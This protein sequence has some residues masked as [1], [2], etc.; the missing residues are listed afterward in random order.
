MRLAYREVLTLG[1]VGACVGISL[2]FT[3]QFTVFGALG[4]GETMG[5]MRRMGYWG[6]VMA[7]SL[8]ISYGTA[9]LTMYVVREWRQP[10]IVL[11][12]VAAWA[13]MAA[14]C[15]AVTFTSYGV[16]QAVGTPAVA[17]PRVA[18]HCALTV[19]GAVALMY[20]VLCVRV[21][22]RSRASTAGDGVMAKP[23]DAVASRTDAAETPPSEERN[24][25]SST[26]SEEQTTAAAGEHTEA[27]PSSR[28]FDRLPEELGTDI[29]YLAAAAHYVDVIT[30]AGSA[31]I[32]L[33]FSDAAA[34]LGDLGMRVHRSYWV[35][36]RHVRQAVRREG[37][38]VLLLTGDHEVRVGRNYLPEVRAAVPKAWAR[39]RR[40]VANQAGAARPTDTSAAPAGAANRQP[41]ET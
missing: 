12:L 29:I 13:V 11:A 33:R 14:S 5:W 16:F 9:A 19:G 27:A 20:H 25:A 8:P 4:T 6:L 23:A 22:V 17:L 30:A 35:A 3:V 10:E 15:T 40:L 21:G 7:L 26:R 38:P 28:F 36:Y 34:E 2:F 1:M 18:A 31:S 37:R 24:S 39:A 41:R 32:L